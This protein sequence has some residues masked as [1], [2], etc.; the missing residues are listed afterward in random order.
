MCYSYINDEYKRRKFR[1]MKIV[2][3]A[4]SRYFGVGTS[5]ECYSSC[6]RIRALDSS[7]QL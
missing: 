4:F 7:R 5:P 1:V 6:A 2:K 3:V